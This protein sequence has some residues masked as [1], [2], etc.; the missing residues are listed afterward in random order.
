M[1]NKQV[2]FTKHAKNT[3]LILLGRYIF[4]EYFEH[5]YKCILAIKLIIKSLY[6]CTVSF[7]L[8]YSFILKLER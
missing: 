2:I 4:V 6:F 3:Y 8:S 1:Y 5:K 7:I